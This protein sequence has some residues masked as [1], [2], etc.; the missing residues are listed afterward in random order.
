MSKVDLKSG[1][2]Q[3]TENVELSHVQLDKLIQIQKTVFPKASWEK[4]NNNYKIIK[5][6]GIAATIFIAVMIGLFYTVQQ[7]AVIENIAYEVSKN[8]LKLKPLEVS[9]NQ[10]KD[11]S[12]YFTML[13]FKLVHTKIL[14]DSKWELLGGR[15]C[16]IQG[17]TAAQLRIKNIS[18]GQMETLY[19]APYDADQYNRIP[20]FENDQIPIQEFSKGMGVEIW[21]E[22][23][24]LFALTNSNIEN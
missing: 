23:G 7:N 19:Q 13:D 6:T 24:V 3:H 5:I 17:N 21:V 11:L 16:T 22:K 12:E 2:Q 18:T 20:S 10:L 14:N 4:I 1:L 9:T 15:Y 8:H